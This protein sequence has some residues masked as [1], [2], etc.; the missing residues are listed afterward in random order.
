MATQAEA[1]KIADEKKPTYGAT[2][3]QG[4]GSAMS[5]FGGAV[6]GA[7]GIAAGAASSLSAA[8]L[9]GKDKLGSGYGKAL[10]FYD[11]LFFKDINKEFGDHLEVASR[12]AVF[13]VICAIPFVLPH[14]ICPACRDIVE[15]GIYKAGCITYFIYTLYLYTGDILHFAQGGVFGTVLAVFNIW[16]MQGFMP[17]G[18]TASEPHRWYVGS[19]WA[20]L[21]I[22]LLLWLN[23]DANTR[24]FGISTYVWY[25]MSFI[26]PDATAGFSQGFEVK[27]DGKAVKEFMVAAIGCG[28]AVVAAYVPYPIY[29][30]KKAL[31]TTKNMLAQVYMTKQDFMAYYCGGNA[32]PLAIKILEREM[33]ALRNETGAIAGLL[34]SA[35]YECLGRGAW[36][37]QQVMMK[38]FSLYVSD[39]VDQLSNVFQVCKSE[40]F[41]DSHDKLMAGIKE[42]LNK[43]IESNAEVLKYCVAGLYEGSFN[44]DLK[45][46]TEAEMARGQDAIKELTTTFVALRAEADYNKV[47]EACTGENVCALT[48]AKFTHSTHRLYKDLQDTEGKEP[49]GAWS[50]PLGIFNPGVLFDKDHIMWTMRNSISIILAFWAGWQGYGQYIASYNAALASTVAVLL[51]NFVGSAMVKNLARLQGVVLGIVLGNLLY[52]FLAWCYWWGHLLVGL[53]LYFWTLMGLFMYFHSTNYSTVGLLLAVFGA[54]G[55]LKPCANEDTVPGGLSAIVNVTVAIVIMTVV[56]MLLSSARASD[57]AMDNFKKAYSAETSSVLAAINTIFDKAKEGTGLAGV[58]DAIGAA[59][60]MGNEAGM[61]P[62]YWRHDWPT[63]KYNRGISCLKTL[64]FCLDSIART[65]ITADGK[66]KQLFMDV[67]DLPAFINLKATLVN[68]VTQVM[69]TVEKSIQDFPGDGVTG[70]DVFLENARLNGIEENNMIARKNFDEVWREKMKTLFEELN[71]SMFETQTSKSMFGRTTASQPAGA[72]VQ[73]IS[74]GPLAE[75]SLL[76]ESLKAMFEDLDTTLE[77]MAS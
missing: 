65:M 74:E 1:S 76:V 64:R 3:K 55:L 43:L 71:K 25:A 40:D 14:A 53:A 77:K 8:G 9:S 26:Q 17:G 18:Y 57:I 33:L 75:C 34:D 73:D 61:E 54:Q 6:R 23:F 49:S 50:G 29:A 58:A 72:Q 22:I 12:G 48:F 39:T 37:K 21:F 10:G 52:A 5:S 4:V 45:N 67:L 46:E 69:E 11:R 27:L 36:A 35:W 70:Y 30:H 16:C 15:A 38:T 20:M 28:L 66:K 24:I 7:G 19:L 59:E 41:A 2:L 32:D 42:P 44:D 13:V 63:D 56:D 60:S 31:E 68:H 62:R 51:S 47:D